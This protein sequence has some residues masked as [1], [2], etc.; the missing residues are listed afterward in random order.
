MQTLALFAQAMQSDTSSS[1]NAT[2]IVVGL[3]LAVVFVIALW[4]VFQKANQPGW[5]A[6][7]PFYNIYV[8]VKIAGRPGWWVILYLIPL[9]NVITHL[10]VAIDTA[11]AFG[12]SGTF[13]FFGLWLFSFIG[14]LILG[15]GDAKYQGVPK[16]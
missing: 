16:H 15:F 12:K 1:S 11:K 4:R 10:V 7:I 14:Y 2:S 9:V 5:A 6:I 13:G 8:M 3:I